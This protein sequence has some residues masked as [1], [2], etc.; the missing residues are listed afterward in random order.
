MRFKAPLIILGLYLIL[1]FLAGCETVKG[2]AKGGAEGFSED[3]ENTKKVD[4][5]MR[6]TLW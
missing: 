1:I 6:E 2:A 4:K 3:W 5:W